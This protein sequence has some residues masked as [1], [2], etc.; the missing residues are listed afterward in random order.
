[1]MSAERGTRNLSKCFFIQCSALII[2]RF[3][4]GCL[5]KVRGSGAKSVLNAAL[6]CMMALCFGFSPAIALEGSEKGL[7]RGAR[8]LR[9]GDFE[10]A[11]K[12]FRELLV[13][14]KQ[15]L[16][17]R[18]GLSAALLKQRKLQDA[19]DHAARVLMADPASHQ[20]H[21]L[22]GEALLRSGDFRLSVEEFRTALQFK[23]NNPVAVA[24]LAMVAF[25]ENRLNES[26][27]GLRRAVS[28]DPE[29][30]D[31]QFQLGQIAA[32][33]EHYKEAAEAF[34]RFLR[35]APRTDVDRRARIRGLIDFL[36][37][38][39][40]QSDLVSLGGAQKTVIPFELVNNRP[41]VRVRINGS[42]ETFRFVVDS[43]SGM[44]VVS[45]RT[46]ERI[47]LKPVA[48]G[49]MA[50]AV[51]GT[52]RFEIVYGF[53]DSIQFGE[54]KV[55]R[56]PVYLREFF[57]TSEA[58]DGYIGVSLLSKY[59]TLVDFGEKTITMLR[60]Q[61]R[62]VYDP[63][64]PPPGIE[65]PIRITS[66]GFWSGEIR[67]DDVE[68]P[69]NFIIDTGATISVVSQALAEREEA[70]SR[71]P[72]NDMVKVFGAAGLADNVQTLRLPRIHLGKYTQHNVNAAVLDMNPINE[73][74]GFE[75]TGIV[76]GNVLKN[77]RVTFD[78]ERGIVRLEPLATGSP[79]ND[80]IS[81]PQTISTEP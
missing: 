65:I 24:G 63:L 59:Q 2:Y 76:G 52:G 81:E 14:D 53:L 37:Y 34:E 51:G 1:M 69:V 38:L 64:Q 73:T 7:K 44:C 72:R 9:A 26:L 42:K 30:P 33:S 27:A 79:V 12:I 6:I 23:E 56:V 10:D 35:I 8:A 20:A 66:S 78:F 46:A 70:I 60:D 15:N 45:K 29:E 4:G 67:I 61:A 58:V 18:L 74:S 80:R 40:T 71:F 47:G 3:D 32:H 16:E 25:Y 5:M 36:R 13:K 17:A 77:F 49:G 48:R 54:A 11:E 41:I 28:I 55:D 43:G 31:Y 62:P 19:F 68:K 21:A 75:Q 57:N 22:L 50:R 39:G